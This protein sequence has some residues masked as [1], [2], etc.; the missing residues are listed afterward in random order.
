MLITPEFHPVP[1][2]ARNNLETVLVKKHVPDDYVMIQADGLLNC[3][4][5]TTYYQPTDTLEY[6]LNVLESKIIMDPSPSTLFP[7]WSSTP[8]P[9]F[10]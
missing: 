3:D 10:V 2:R 6:C 4:L 8:Y 9:I 1:Y 7:I 5:L